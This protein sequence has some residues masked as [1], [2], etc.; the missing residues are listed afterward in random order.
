M[1]GNIQRL[2]CLAC[3]ELIHPDTA[4]KNDGLCAPCKGGY[5]EQIE[6]GR[7]Q[8]RHERALERSPERIYWRIL[9]QRVHASREAFAR[10]PQAERTYYALRMLMGEVCNGG[11]H[12]LFANNSGALYALMLDGLLELEADET[13]GLLAEAKEL[14]LGRGAVP[15]DE[16]ERNE[17]LPDPEVLAK[18]MPWRDARLR[19]IEEAFWAGADALDE[20]CTRYAVAQGLYPAGC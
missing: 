19:E 12:A 2:R 5:R 13:L 8:R 20:Q 11:F 15:L 17:L 3:G 9:V 14:L 1:N 7:R 10:L 16:G 6:E 4:A 18:L